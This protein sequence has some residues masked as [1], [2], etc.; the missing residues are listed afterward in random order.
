M[1]EVK[2]TAHLDFLNFVERFAVLIIPSVVVQ[3]LPDK[4]MGCSDPTFF[5][6]SH[7]KVV[8]EDHFDSTLLRSERSCLATLL[9]IMI[10]HMHEI[11]NLSI[12]GHVELL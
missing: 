11:P 9:K 1:V 10:D 3:V 5:R 7:M 12:I 4:L 2:G 6:P 8:N